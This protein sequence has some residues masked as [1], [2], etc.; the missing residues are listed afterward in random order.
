[1]GSEMCIRDSY[2]ALFTRKHENKIPSIEEEIGILEEPSPQEKAKMDREYRI[3]K[4]G[5]ILVT[6]IALGIYIIPV[7]F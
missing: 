1:M 6:V 4:A 5:T 7:L 3:W 2:W